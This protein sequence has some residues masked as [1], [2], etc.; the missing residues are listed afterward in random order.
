MHISD[1][2]ICRLT[3]KKDD[4]N[5]IFHYNG[6]FTNCTYNYNNLSNKLLF[7][8]IDGYMNGA[9]L[10]E[11]FVKNTVK[12]VL[13][14][15]G[16]RVY[17]E[18][19]FFEIDSTVAASLTSVEQFGDKIKE[20]QNH[21]LSNAVRKYPHFDMEILKRMKVMLNQNDHYKSQI[22]PYYYAM[23]ISLDDLADEI[24]EIRKMFS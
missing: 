22:Q 5:K 9:L 1:Q 15:M 19:K 12:K 24:E 16:I 23:N 17:V 10:D 21:Y 20:V 4:L 6:A 3:L 2:I 8:R 14:L 11:G 18:K 7:D 13:Y